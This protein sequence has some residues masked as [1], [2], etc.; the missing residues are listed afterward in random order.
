MHL[1]YS[2]VAKAFDGYR[3][4]IVI[5]QVDATVVGDDDPNI[6][7]NLSILPCLTFLYIESKQ[8]W[9]PTGV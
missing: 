1:Y 5:A 2:K 4:S 9:Q 8:N 6:G 3:E 7:D